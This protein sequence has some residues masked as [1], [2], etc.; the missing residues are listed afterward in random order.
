MSLLQHMSLLIPQPWLALI[1]AAIFLA[2]G[3]ALKARFIQGVGVA[4]LLYC[5]LELGNK[6]RVT[7]SGECDIRVDLLLIYPAL[8]LGS[9][10][11]F[12]V[13]VRKFFARPGA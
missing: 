5:L 10:A 11:A 8:A 13:A 3:T 9:V 1:P 7:C 4:W 6:Y 12:M 2:V